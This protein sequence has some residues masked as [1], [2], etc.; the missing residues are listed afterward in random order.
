MS[1]RSFHFVPL[2]GDFGQDDT[3]G[4]ALAMRASETPP[5]RKSARAAFVKVYCTILQYRKITGEVSQRLF[6]ALRFSRAVASMSFMR[7]SWLTFVAE[8]S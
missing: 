5:A 4:A 7:F 3:N 1:A 2:S 6:Y 8:G